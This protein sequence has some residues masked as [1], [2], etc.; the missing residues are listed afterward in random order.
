MSKT[1]LTELNRRYLSQELLTYAIVI[2]ALSY[3]VFVCFAFARAHL[4]SFLFFIVFG[5]GIGL[6]FGIIYRYASLKTIRKILAN[7]FND[8]ETMA[9][10]PEAVLQARREAFKYPFTLALGLLI[11]W[12]LIANIFAIIPFTLMHHL[13]WLEFIFL[14]LFLFFAC[15]SSMPYAFLN[16]EIAIADFL[17]LPV[18]SV[19]DRDARHI[20]KFRLLPKILSLMVTIVIPPLGYVITVIFIANHYHLELASIKWGFLILTGQALVMATLTGILFARHIKSAVDEILVFLRSMVQRQGDLTRTIAVI[21]ND[22]MGELTLWFARY[23]GNLR[24]MVKDIIVNAGSL[25]ASSHDLSDLSAKMS[26]GTDRMSE[27]TNVVSSSAEEMS[28]A[29]SSVSAAMNQATTNVNLVASSVE[30]MSATINEIAG[31]SEKAR[32]MTGDAVKYAG[33]V[34]GE[35]NRLE[36]AARSISQV[37]EV[38]SEISDQTNLLALNATI[39]AARAGEAGKGFSVVAGEIKE[40]AGQTTTAANEI[41]T[42]IDGIQY[43][44]TST[45]S[46]VERITTIIDKI[47]GIVDSIASA[48][49]EQSVSAKEIANNISQVSAGN[50][51]V[52]Q[53]MGQS[54]TVAGGIAKEIAEIHD[55]ANEVASGSGMLNHS[56]QQLSALAEELHK[57]VGKFT[58]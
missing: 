40:L 49:E 8:P 19:S 42:M 10:D 20:W 3:F 18:M 2:P 36:T 11:R 47:N 50:Q 14:N 54:S 16:A 58:T 1:V 37:T 21:S 33:N 12:C 52:N 44:A 43:S 45:I 26:A 39:E 30:Q 6:C 29:L 13:S 48:V 56:A 34:T 46:E 53:K 41:R 25:N 35:V 4:Q 24:A 32:A 22:E 57:M 17:R 51:E 28:T 31:N 27:R 23:L 7:D 5:G 9:G 15:I 55:A 38:I